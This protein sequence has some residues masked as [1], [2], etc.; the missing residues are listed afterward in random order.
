MICHGSSLAANSHPLIKRHSTCGQ[1]AAVVACNGLYPQAL[2][3]AE[4]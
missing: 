3:R 2:R 4:G 1:H